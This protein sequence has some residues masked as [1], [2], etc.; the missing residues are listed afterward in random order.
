MNAERFWCWVW[1]ITFPT[2]LAALSKTY[3]PERPVFQLLL[4]PS[5]AIYWI[6]TRP[7]KQALGV[8]ICFA[9]LCET[10]WLIPTGSCITFFLLIW[11]FVRTYREF[12]PIRPSPYH[13]LLCGVI[14]LPLLRVWL[15]IYT[16]L[17]PTIPTAAFL[18]PSLS[19]IILIP[20]LGALGSS[21][22]F[23]LAQRMEFHIFVPKTEEL[24]DDEN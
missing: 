10:I 18:S 16:A 23:A 11:W 17:T 22:I 19:E 13:G 4:L 8:A 15:W 21:A 1:L 3:L 12:L 14:L 7:I 9:F 2:L 20:A 6:F 5:W 24:R